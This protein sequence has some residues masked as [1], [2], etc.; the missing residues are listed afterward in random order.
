MPADAMPE[1]YEHARCLKILLPEGL[2][3]FPDEYFDF[4]IHNHVLEHIPGSFRE[5]MDGLCRVVARGGK[6]IFSVPGP[7]MSMLTIEGGEHLADDEARLA[8]FGQIN[9]LKLFGRDLPEYLASIPYGR[10]AF[11]DLSPEERA[12][13][14]VRQGS[15]RFLIWE[16]TASSSSKRLAIPMRY[17]PGAARAR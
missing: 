16:R 5:H 9:H 8:R 1:V 15:N 13:I 6:L 7:K 3:L 12:R 14:S 2:D 10:F 4:V 17:V 11:D